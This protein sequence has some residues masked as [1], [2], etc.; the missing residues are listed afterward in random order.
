MK[1][2]S[3]VSLA[4]TVLLLR[5]AYTEGLVHSGLHIHW[6][7]HFPW[8]SRRYLLRTWTLTCGTTALII[9]ETSGR[10]VWI[11]LG[12][13]IHS[14]GVSRSLLRST[15]CNEYVVSYD[16]CMRGRT[17]TYATGFLHLF[18]AKPYRVLRHEVNMRYYLFVR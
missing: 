3:L 8:C 17:L 10:S 11:P 1:C 6:Y 12:L 4:L 7:N 13:Q 5:I 18:L 2:R 14:S 15:C 9:S 16:N